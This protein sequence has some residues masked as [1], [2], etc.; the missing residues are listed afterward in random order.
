MEVQEE[1][2]TQRLLELQGTSGKQSESHDPMTNPV[3]S[4]TLNCGVTRQR[5]AA[6]LDKAGAYGL[7]GAANCDLG[8]VLSIHEVCENI[9]QY[10][11]A[12]VE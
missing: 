11:K 9:Q 6:K 1:P 7:W 3:S 5:T 2:G 4:T 12:I 10:R 8:K